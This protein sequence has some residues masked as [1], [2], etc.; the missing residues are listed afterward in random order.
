MGPKPIKDGSTPHDAHETILTNG[1]IELCSACFLV[2][3]TVAAAPSFIPDEFPGV[4]VP[5]S[6]K[7][8]F[9]FFKSSI[10]KSPLGCSSLSKI[11]FSFF[12]SICNLIIS[13]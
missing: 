8:V 12:L 7:T 6:L 4:T 13:S 11:K 1:S 9:S 3:S 10:I 5:F 2:I